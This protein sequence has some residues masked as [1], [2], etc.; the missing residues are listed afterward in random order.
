MVVLVCVD[1]N[2]IFDTRHLWRHILTESAQLDLHTT[3]LKVNH[4]RDA[5]DALDHAGRERRQQQFRRIKSVGPAG[6][7]RIQGDFRPLAPGDAPMRVDPVRSYY[8]L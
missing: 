7:I 2:V 1:R 8:V 3:A 5:L 4:G 6:E